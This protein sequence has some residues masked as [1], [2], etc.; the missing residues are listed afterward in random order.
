MSPIRLIHVT[1]VPESLHFLRGQAAYMGARGIALQAVSSPGPELDAFGEAENVPVHGV[2][3][4][5]AITPL[6]DL[7][8][9]AR[10]AA[11]LRRERPHVVHAH[12]P[13]GGLLGMMAARLAGVPVRV[14]HMRGL[15]METATG[16]RRALLRSTE[17]VSCSLAHRVICVSHSLRAAALGAGLCPPD[18]LRVLAGGSGQGVEA[19]RRFHPA[20]VPP[21]ERA[22]VRARF[23][24]PGDAPVVGFVGRIVRDKGGVE[25]A[26]AWR[27]LRGAHPSAHLLMVGPFEPRDPL[28]PGVEAELRGDPRVHLAGMDWET[29]RLYAAMDLVVLPTYREGFPNV[30]LEAAAM[31]RPVVAT[32]VPGC[33]DAVEE[34]V[35]GTL[36][37]PRD[38][39]ALAAAIAA[40]LADPGL[41]AAHGRAGRARVLRDF[42][43]EAIWEALVH[44]YRGLLGAR[45]LAVPAPAPAA[46]PCAE[47]PGA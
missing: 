4:P 7:S 26:E 1:T 29:P 14:Y 34:G 32:R 20:L 47:G 38:A 10:L 15:P 18:K 6:R 2:R 33:V 28:P 44:E 17:R 46:A 25:L 27:V 31:E 21:G 13:K 37:P 9:V 42:R 22:A 11:V 39:G 35:T 24:I 23:G 8:A 41:G 45:G 36:V 3:M 19:E 16:A 12:T 5:R 30:L 40:Y 43:R